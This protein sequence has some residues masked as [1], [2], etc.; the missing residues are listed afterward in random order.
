MTMLTLALC[1]A[2]AVGAPAIHQAGKAGSTNPIIW[3]DVPDPS[4]VRVGDTFY[5]S[6]TT[7]HMSPGLPIMKSKNLVDWKLA[8][9]AYE[10]LGSQDELALSNGKNAYGSGSWASSLRYH[11]GVFY[12]TTFSFTTG[13][14]YIYR[15]KS[16]D[17]TPWEGVSFSPAYHDHSLFFDD[18]GRIYMVYGAGDIRIVELKSDL[19]GPMPGGVQQII[20]PN[21]TAVAG[22]Q[23]GL[24]A[25]GSQ[26]LKKDGK[27]YL[28]NI[29]WPRG[30]MR[31]EL[32]HRADHIT[33]PYEGRILFKDRGIA[34][35]SLIDTPEGD[36]F[37]YLFQDCG[38]VGRIPWLVPAKWIDGWPTVGIE[39]RAPAA[40]D[41]P[42]GKLGLKGIVSSD[43]FSRRHGEPDLPLAW[44]WNH[45]PVRSHWSLTDR[46]GHL[47][48]TSSRV[49][50]EVLQARNILT[51][52]TYGPTSSATTLVDVSHLKNG[53][54]AGLLLLQRKFGLI[55]V[56][57]ENGTRKIVMIGAPSDRPETMGEVPTDAKN[58]YLR[59][60][61]D[62]RQRADLARFFYSFDGK[63]WEALGQVLKLRYDLPH[64]M[65]YR[66]GLF[67][68]SQR[69][70]GGFADF[71]HYRIS[72]TLIPPSNTK[73]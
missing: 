8:S 41:L 63:K 24:P 49:D 43:E 51:Q 65:G 28:F 33:G 47:R 64:F 17:K 61:C 45:N 42:K 37:A 53:D 21:A 32:V 4:M 57:S 36:W 52:R 10:T 31:M 72:D 30:G 66:F 39:G 56:R 9:Y 22:G 38:A 44:Q 15:T 60:D 67:I 71:D 14:T 1:I 50:A 62:F 55:G 59:I 69:E 3:A 16:P 18:D 35:G 73:K 23:P 12:A 13:K 68:H 40:L 11:N 5:M 46:P 48:L 7:M 27:Y 6:S 29:T 20:V 54:T 19:T 58:I 34:Q 26:I 25:E 70:V 2:L